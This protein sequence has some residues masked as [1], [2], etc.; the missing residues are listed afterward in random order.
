MLDALSRHCRCCRLAAAALALLAAAACTTLPPTLDA[1]KT[2]TTALATP[3]STS[4]GRSVAARAK[5]HP[6]LSGFRLLVDGKDSFAMRLRIASKAERTLDL[7]YFLFQQDDT[8]RLLLAAMLAAADRGVRVRLLLDDAQAFDA[9]SM[10]RPLAAHPNIEIR[11]Y[12]PFVAR[13]QFAFL[14]GAE[15]L[16]ESGRLNYR[17]H[18]KLFVADNAV[19]ITGGRNVGDEYF[20]ASST[21]EFGD[22]D[23]AVGGPMVQQLS[24]GFD[25]YWNDKLA[26]PVETLPLGKPSAADLEKCRAALAE[27]SRKMADSDYVRSLPQ[28]DRLA[29]ILSAKSTLVWAKAEFAYD[30]PDKAQTTA[31]EQPGR[32]MWKRVARAAEGAKE[33]LIIVSPYLV[34]GDTEMELLR[35]L[36][37]QNV[38]IRILTNSLASTDMPVAHAGYLVC[39]VPLLE[40]GV[41]LFEVRTTL[42]APVTRRGLIKSGSSD[43]F[44]LHAKVFVIDRQRVFVGSMNFDQR[45][46]NINTEQ[47]LVIDSPELAREIAARFE[48]IVQ[49]ANS[50]RLELDDVGAPTGPTL[51]W[52]SVEDGK[53]VTYDSEPGVDAVKRA[54]VR[55]LSLLPLDHLL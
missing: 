53:T 31:G 35:R 6:G 1:P 41:E 26:V 30:T 15:F 27:H 45:S 8:G 14:R 24:R 40:A 32:L 9:D 21:V 23:L 54:R 38:R 37:A 4:L 48:A 25:L 12:N 18:N 19:A 13:R 36:R 7:Q 10:I 43:Q 29:E 49:P 51:R 55:F 34:P 2:A 20:Q 5:E 3:E 50:Y 33:E 44:A 11:I 28:G 16:L 22:F 42:G 52:V 46:L 39:R 47:G 17:M